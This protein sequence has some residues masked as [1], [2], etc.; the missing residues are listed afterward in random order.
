MTDDWRD[1]VRWRQIFQGN[2]LAGGL[3]TLPASLIFRIFWLI[4]GAE[5]PF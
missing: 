5:L 3:A 4:L 1:G 2:I